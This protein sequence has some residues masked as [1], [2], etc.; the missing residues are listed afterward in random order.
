MKNKTVGII[1][2]NLEDEKV[3]QRQFQRVEVKEFIKYGG[4]EENSYDDLKNFLRKIDF[5]IIG[6]NIEKEVVEK[7]KPKKPYIVFSGKYAIDDM[8]IIKDIFN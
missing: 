8:R 6:E 4:V 5:L 2:H 1:S 7:L 3:I